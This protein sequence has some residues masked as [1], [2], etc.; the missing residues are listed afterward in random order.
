MSLAHNTA[1]M[2]TA[3]R[4]R[5]GFWG[6][7]LG[8]PQAALVVA[9]AIAIGLAFH[10]GIGYPDAAL[11][12]AQTWL[13]GGGLAAAF[14]LAARRW[15]DHPVLRWLTGI[16][17]AL[18][19]LSG[20]GAL[21]AVGAVVPSA[22]LESR[23]GV[24]SVFSSWPFRMGL[25]VLL[26]N[27]IGVTARRIWP[28]TTTNFVFTLS[29]LGLTLALL[30]GML[31]ATDLERAN[32]VAYEGR[33]VSVARRADG[34][35]IHLPFAV[36]L[37]RFHL[38]CFPPTLAIAAS[39]DHAPGGFRVTPGPEFVRPNMRERI[40]GYAIEVKRFLPRAALVGDHWHEVAMNTGAP[41]AYVIA[42]DRTGKTTRAGWVSCGGVDTTGAYL[43]L[44]ATRAL[45]MPRPR[46]REYRS[47]V[48]IEEP[49]APAAT[50]DIRVNA[51]GRVGP[52]RLYQLSYD[53]E[54]GAA[55]EVSVI[56]VVRDRGLPVVYT[57]MFLLLAGALLGLWRAR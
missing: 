13:A 23:F 17:F 12:P 24:D 40:G 46:A 56:E 38:A 48:T 51:P 29:H 18:C 5:Q 22:T 35:T 14:A 54:R 32:L 37:R 52:Y 30:G 27:L 4:S 19:S 28:L 7:P 42:R 6:G 39:D 33:P 26:V 2:V 45:Y 25:I 44:D 16:P 43:R 20:V 49:H 21:A 31:G 55:S 53:E 1:A 11:S 15:R 50:R 9:T 36:T 10:V 57:G 41:A 47:T 8:Y 34:R 3:R